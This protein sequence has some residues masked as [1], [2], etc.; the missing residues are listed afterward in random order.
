MPVVGSVAV[1]F[2]VEETMPDTGQLNNSCPDMLALIVSD[3]VGII[4]P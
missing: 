1:P 3:K 4:S 2:I